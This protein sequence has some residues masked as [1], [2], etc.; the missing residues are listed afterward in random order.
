[1][2]P[3]LS[4]LAATPSKANAR[5]ASTACSARPA[6]ATGSSTTHGCWP[7]WTGCSCPTTCSPSCRSSTSTPARRPAPPPRRRDLPGAPAPA[8]PGSGNG[9][10]HRR[11]HRRQRRHRGPAGEPLLGQRP[12]TGRPRHPAPGHDAT[13]LVRVL[14]RH[15]VAR[16][17]RQPV[18]KGPPRHHRAVL[19]TVAA[20][21]G[22]VH[23]VD[24]PRHG[25]GGV[26]GHPPDA[27]LQ[28]PPAVRRHAPPKVSWTP[29]AAPSPDRV[30]DVP[31][32]TAANLR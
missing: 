20:P 9:V 32:G 24:R 17:W 30:A 1:V 31:G 29:E 16:W 2:T 22:S 8:A 6:R 19:R 21:S 12:Q 15:F 26:R 28:R 25:P 23:L 5:N 7:C 4:K 11:L 18:R 13:R 27:G 14:R 10:G 3:L